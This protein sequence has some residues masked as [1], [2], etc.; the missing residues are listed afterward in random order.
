MSVNRLHAPDVVLDCFYNDSYHLACLLTKIENS[1]ISDIK[2]CPKC[3]Q[4]ATPVL[5][6][7]CLTCFST[8]IKVDLR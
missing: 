1:K 6:I 8:Y 5:K 7:F 3:M 2:L 4:P